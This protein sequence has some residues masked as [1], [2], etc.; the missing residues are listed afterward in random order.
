M[1]A[2]VTE[3]TE[4]SYMLFSMVKGEFLFFFNGQVT[5]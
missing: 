2:W 4:V 1:G 5:N 3:R